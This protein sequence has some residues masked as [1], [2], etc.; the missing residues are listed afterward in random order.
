MKILVGIVTYYPN[1]ESLS[2]TCEALNDY[3]VFI[4]DN[5][6]DNIGIA[7]ALRK[8]MDHAVQNGYDWV[9]TLDQDSEIMPGLIEEYT[10]N[11]ASDIGAMTCI[12][13]DRNFEEKQQC[14]DVDWCITSGCFMN[15]RAYLR[16]PGYDE[17]LF[18]DMVDMDI[19]YSLKEAGFRIVRIPFEG[20]KHEVGY[21]KKTILGYSYNHE[22]WRDYYIA[23]NRLVVG[24]KHKIKGTKL[25]A[26]RDI[27]V[28]LLFED[29]KKEKIT[30]MRNGMADACKYLGSNKGESI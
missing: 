23:R 4:H 14:G 30:M 17:S 10:E 19:C 11:V 22:P 13:R 20:L 1:E 27:A 15:V 8:I 24:N 18:I 2:K 6:N 9:L 21:G 5:T 25:R 26:Y 29:N 28:V 12:I 3:D 7:S 16:T